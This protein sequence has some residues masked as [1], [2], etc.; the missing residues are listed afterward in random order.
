MALCKKSISADIIS[1]CTLT[2]IKGLEP[3]A[4]IFNYEDIVPIPILDESLNI[5]N[6]KLKAGKKGYLL[7]GYKS[8]FD[9]GHEYV[10]KEK[11]V[12]G[13]KHIFKF[14]AFSIRKHAISNVD[15]MTNIVVV[16]ETK[17][18]DM[19]QK[20]ESG[21]D[22]TFKCF[23]MRNG[24]EKKASNKMYNDNDGVRTLEFSTP[25]DLTESA[26]EYSFVMNNSADFIRN[27]LNN[28]L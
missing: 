24:L 27:L 19:L 20:G 13:Y 7:K 18:S 25:D 22:E 21:T 8:N 6:F 28:M 17:N 9:T 2:P 10:S 26:S 23:G 16:T 15:A 3:I 14:D 1:D 5:N 4:W 12:N 11:R